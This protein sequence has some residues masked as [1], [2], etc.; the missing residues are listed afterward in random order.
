MLWNGNEYGKSKLI[1]NPKATVANTD[2][3]IS[4]TAEECEIFQLFW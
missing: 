4:K 1:E 2:Y 3:D